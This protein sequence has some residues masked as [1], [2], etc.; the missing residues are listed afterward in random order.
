MRHRILVVGGY[1]TFGARTVEL[2]EGRAEL[3]IVVAGRSLESA[4]RFCRSRGSTRATLLPARFDRDG[5]AVVQLAAIRPDVLLDASGPFQEYGQGAYR[6]VE[7]CIA[8]RA[9]YLDLADGSG[10]VAGIPAFDAAARG[11]GVFVLSGVSSFPVLTSA[12]VRHLSKGMSRVRRI[13]GGIAPSPFA[14]VG[15]NVIRAIAGYAGQPVP[16]VRDGRPATGYPFTDHLRRTVSVPGHEPLGETLFSLVDVPDL[17]VLAAQWPEAEEVWMGA[18]PVPEILHRALGALAWLVRWGLVGSLLPLAPLMHWATNH[19]RWGDHRGGM[20]VEV[21][22][23]S[24]GGAALDRSWQMIAEGD[25]GPMIPAMAVEGVVLRVLDGRPPVPGA[26]AAVEDLELD[27]YE[28]LFARR[29]IFTA[30]CPE[31]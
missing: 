14:G 12:V 1:G 27:D 2:L 28:A 5:D 4:E 31:S 23:D 20:F 21:E 9:N 3:E 24:P 18:G 8:A 16:M 13:R 19:I 15:P 29:R 6:L 25:D 11:A 7:G 17:R 22:G 26:R 30:T 10:F